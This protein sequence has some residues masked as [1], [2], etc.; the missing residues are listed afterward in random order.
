MSDYLLNK[1]LIY[2]YKFISVYK[3]NNYINY[4]KNNYNN[5][6]MCNQY[7]DINEAMKEKENFSSEE[8]IILLKLLEE[9]NEEKNLLCDVTKHIGEFCIFQNHKPKPKPKPKVLLFSFDWDACTF[10]MNADFPNSSLTQRFKMRDFYEKQA[11]RPIWILDLAK[12]NSQNFQNHVNKVKANFPNAEIAAVPGTYRQDQQICKFNQQHH[13]KGYL[14]YDNYFKGVVSKNKQERVCIED[15]DFHKILKKLNIPLWPIFYADGDGEVGSAM[16]NEKLTVENNPPTKLLGADDKPIK[17]KYNMDKKAL[18][19]SQF[20]K[21]ENRW[22]NHEIHIY[23][24]DD[25]LKYIKAGE[26]VPRRDNW[27]FHGVH[28]DSQPLFIG[29]EAFPKK[30]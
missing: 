23:F 30:V 17:F 19:A 3:K 28:F 27:H 24:Y 1:K 7:D 16:R 20:A 9:K 2:L 29:K 12:K 18:I 6:A 14:I 13:N 25:Q 15:G 26:S 22:P 10:I 11:G 8:L 5:M 4:K 21:A